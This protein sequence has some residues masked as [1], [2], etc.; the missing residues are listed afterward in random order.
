MNDFNFLYANKLITMTFI[1]FACVI[2]GSAFAAKKTSSGTINIHVN[3]INPTCHSSL[4]GNNLSLSCD[5]GIKKI[6]PGEIKTGE[7]FER[8]NSLKMTY[9]NASNSRG[10]ISVTYK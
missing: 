5:D 9:I 8:I 7:T 2:S 10:V 3:I 4:S 1:L 6:S